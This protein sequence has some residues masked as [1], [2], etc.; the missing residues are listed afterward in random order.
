MHFKLLPEMGEHLLPESLP[1]KNTLVT[2]GS[3]NSSNFRTG[4]RSHF[5]KVRRPCSV[6]E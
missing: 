3:F 2:N 6:M 5:S 4:S 1:K